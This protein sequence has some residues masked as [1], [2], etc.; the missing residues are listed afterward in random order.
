[1]PSNARFSAGFTSSWPSRFSVTSIV[2][3]KSFQTMLPQLGSFSFL[4]W[5]FRDCGCGKAISCGDLFREDRPETTLPI[6]K[7]N[8]YEKR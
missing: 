8:R 3:L 4:E 5:F 1:M 7:G 2:R 6:E